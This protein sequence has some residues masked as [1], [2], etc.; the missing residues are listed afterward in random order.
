MSPLLQRLMIALGRRGVPV[1]IDT[2]LGN[3]YQAFQQCHEA[4]PSVF[5]HASEILLA[6][7]EGG[8]TSLTE[9]PARIAALCTMLDRLHRREDL[10][11]WAEDAPVMDPPVPSYQLRRSAPAGV[12]A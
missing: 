4:F 12:G 5:T 10:A 1:P 2:T 7:V 11:A 8:A 3:A 6:E 9:V